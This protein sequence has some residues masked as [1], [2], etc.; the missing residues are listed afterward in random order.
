MLVLLAVDGSASAELARD[1]VANLQWPRSTVIHLLTAY[2]VPVDW[3]GGV[4]STMDWIGDVEDATREQLADD[5]KAMSLPLTNHG[6][7]VES[8]VVRGRPA[9]AIIA[10]AAEL[11]VDLIMTGS[12]GRG[13]LRSMLLGSVAAEVTAHARCPVLVARGASASRLLIATD[14]SRNANA[15][16]DLLET[17]GTFRGN[18]ADAVAVSI[19]DTPAFELMVG[20]YTLG[21]ERLAQKR[22]ELRAQYEADADAMAKRLTEIGIQAT[23]TVRAGDPSHEIL[24]AA[25]HHGSDLIVTGSRGLGGLEQLLLGSVARNVLMHA[26]CSVLI[27]RDGSSTNAEQES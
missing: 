13:P 18:R 27:V 25:V 11:G 20:L 19:P 24:S 15:I 14:G 17:W 3:T 1:L 22:R 26:R 12:R 2:Q 10:A 16:P 5:L 7:A 9:D 23:A 4:G 8:H 21:D 6:L